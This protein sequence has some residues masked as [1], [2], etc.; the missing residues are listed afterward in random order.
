LFCFVLFYPA[1][2]VFVTEEMRSLKTRCFTLND[3]EH[4]LLIFII[5]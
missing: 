5:L 3:V 4:F 1:V 2:S